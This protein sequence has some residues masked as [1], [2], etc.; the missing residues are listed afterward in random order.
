MGWGESIGFSYS[1]LKRFSGD[2]EKEQVCVRNS[3]P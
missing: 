3:K 1:E 2:P